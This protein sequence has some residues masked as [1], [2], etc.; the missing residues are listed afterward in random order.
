MAGK[1]QVII[2]ADAD[3]DVLPSGDGGTDE[4]ALRLSSPQGPAPTSYLPLQGPA[5]TSYLPLF[6]VFLSGIGFSIQTLFIKLLAEDDGLTRS[7]QI[8]FCRGWT[9]L[10]LALFF[11]RF[12]KQED[13]NV[14]VFGGTNRVRFL[15]F[16]R[17]F[18]G[19]LG[20]AFAFLCIELLPIGDGTVLVMLSPLFASMTSWAVLGEPW[21]MGEFVATFVSLTGAALV[22]RPQ[23]LFGSRGGGSGANKAA[24]STGVIYALV[25]AVSAGLAYTI[26]RMLGTTDKMPWANVCFAQALGQIILSPP[27]SWLSGQGFPLNVPAA[28][29]AIIIAAGFIGAWSQIS[30]TVGMQREKSALATGMRMSDVLFGF[31]WQFLFT[32]EAV[33]GL[34]VAGALLV[35]ASVLILVGSKAYY[36]KKG[37]RAG[38]AAGAGAG[39]GAGLEADSMHSIATD[40]AVGAKGRGKGGAQGGLMKTIGGW[41]VYS[42]LHGESQHDAGADDDGRDGGDERMGRVAVDGVRVGEEEGVGVELVGVGAVSGPG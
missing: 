42:A 10:L 28:Q 2:D 16:L 9:Q 1:H 35:V 7:F 12:S 38:E 23:F 22:A 14:P 20:I 36:D 19:F 39:A 18:F 8:I 33:S 40:G 13:R 32:S 15:L 29:F 24:D 30:M 3:A 31:I 37:A 34:S 4:S 26:V 21:R 41:S 6:L 27:S 17:S 11:M 5:P 25:A